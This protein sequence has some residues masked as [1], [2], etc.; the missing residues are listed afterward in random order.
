[1]AYFMKNLNK[2]LL[3]LA[4]TLTTLSTY[5]NAADTASN[6][7]RVLAQSLATVKS[8]IDVVD[9]LK[10]SSSPLNRLS[11][12][13]KYEFINSLSFNEKGVTSFNYKALESE[14]TPTEIYR[15]LSLFG[16]QRLITMFKHARLVSESDY[17]LMNRPENTHKHSLSANELDTSDSVSAVPVF[18]ADHKG[19]KCSSRATCSRSLTEIYTSNC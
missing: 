18:S 1:M 9:E 8:E 6:Y 19:Y 5:S 10:N 12:D 13:A 16:M 7:Q 4:L 11:D 17:L 15:V 3:T 14:L 2:Y